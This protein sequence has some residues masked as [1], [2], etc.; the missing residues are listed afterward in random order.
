VGLETAKTRAALIK[1]A[2]QMGRSEGY[3][4]ITARRLAAKVGLKRQ[5]V[6]YYFR[7]IEELLAAVVR[8]EHER[9]QRGLM[10]ALRSDE[11]LRSAVGLVNEV[12]AVNSEF[13]ALALRHKAIRNEMKRD[14][15]EMR[16]VGTEAVARTFSAHRFLS[17][18]SPAAMA[19]VLGSVVQSLAVE[20]AIGIT[21]GHSETR[22]FVEDWLR[23]CAGTAA[24]PP[25]SPDMPRKA[26]SQRRPRLWSAGSPMPEKQGVAHS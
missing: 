17:P 25:P 3:A 20:Q 13:V 4:S 23:A 18:I 24:P 5:I 11:P 6:H 12:A 15:E 7:T 10:S 19:Y 14:L 26:K 16:R 2:A 22:A 1:A 21:T 9:F 8:F